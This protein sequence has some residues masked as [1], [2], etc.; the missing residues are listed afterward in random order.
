M[1]PNEQ[2]LQTIEDDI[3]ALQTKRVNL[4]TDI[5]GLFE[6][7]SVVP[8]GTPR[9]LYDQIKIYSNSTTYRLYWYDSTSAAW[10]Y[11]SGT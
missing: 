1:D 10:R 9:D 2:R 3:R 6:V 7:V 5:I 11:A 4:N 8:T